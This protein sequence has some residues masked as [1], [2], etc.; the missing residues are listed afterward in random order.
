MP[1]ATL[2]IDIP[3]YNTLDKPLFCLDNIKI[4]HPDN[5]PKGQNV[6]KRQTDGGGSWEPAPKWQWSLTNLSIFPAARYYMPKMMEGRTETPR[7]SSDNGFN[8]RSQVP[9]FPHHKKNGRRPRTPKKLKRARSSS[10]SLTSV[11]ELRYFG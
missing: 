3:S 4:I 8:S 7:V 10:F 5:R 11:L 6:L 2:T 9:F 1:Q